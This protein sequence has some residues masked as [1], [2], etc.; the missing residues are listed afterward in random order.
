MKVLIIAGD[1]WHPM[2]VV[3]RGILEFQDLAPDVEYDFMEDGNE[4]LVRD[5]F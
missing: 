3:K 1:R 5:D 2:E 4:E